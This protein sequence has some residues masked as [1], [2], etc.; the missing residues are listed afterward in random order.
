MQTNFW[1]SL[2]EEIG[3]APSAHKANTD[4]RGHALWRSHL[5]ICRTVKREKNKNYL[6]KINEYIHLSS[7]QL[8][9]PTATRL[10]RKWTQKN[11]HHKCDC[12]FCTLFTLPPINNL[13][14]RAGARARLLARSHAR[15]L[16][17][18]DLSLSLVPLSGTMK[19]KKKKRKKNK[20]C[21]HFTRHCHYIANAYCP[22][23]CVY[24]CAV[25]FAIYKRLKPAQMSQ[26]PS[27]RANQQTIE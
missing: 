12:T 25:Q 14:A 20:L 2:C 22:R 19:W 11:N 3:R 27:E 6:I 21:L 10:Y 24:V 17:L 16:F 26:R 23:M 8:I 13:C 9:G 15:T 5:H 7:K 18:S 4:A 1:S